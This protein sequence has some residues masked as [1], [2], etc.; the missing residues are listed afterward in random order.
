MHVYMYYRPICSIL[1]KYALR[2]FYMFERY[3]IV[4]GVLSDI[5]HLSTTAWVIM[6]LRIS[7]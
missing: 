7:H 2:T 6:F 3:I 1:Q 5:E 4:I